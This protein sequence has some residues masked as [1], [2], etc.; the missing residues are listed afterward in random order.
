MGINNQDVAALAETLK[1]NTSSNILT[2]GYTKIQDAST[3]AETL[4]TNNSIHLLDLPGNQ[5]RRI[6]LLRSL[7]HQHKLEHIEP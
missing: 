4:K 2:L 6:C 1:V 5:I 7:E 3:P